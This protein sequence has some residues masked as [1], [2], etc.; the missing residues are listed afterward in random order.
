MVAAFTGS[1]KSYQ[2]YLSSMICLGSKAASDKNPKL[3]LRA[4]LLPING[5]VSISQSYNVMFES[6]RIIESIQEAKKGGQED[7]QIQEWLEVGQAVA[8]EI[9]QA[10]PTDQAAR[11]MTGIFYVYGG[12]YKRGTK[13]L[14]KLLCKHFKRHIG[15]K[16]VL[17]S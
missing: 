12:D 10:N 16:H 2:S 7:G 14:T 11:L 6:I 4:F 15:D 3:A 9:L 5:K 17:P 13:I 8:Q 1:V